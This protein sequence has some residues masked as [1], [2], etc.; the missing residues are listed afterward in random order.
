M[1]HLYKVEIFG[2]NYQYKDMALLSELSIQMDYLTL[3]NTTITVVNLLAD[4]GDFVHITD[5]YGAIIHQGIVLDV[6]RE[7]NRAKLKVA[8]LHTS[9]R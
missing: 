2:R 8:P 7:S 3:E 9:R 6:A 4:K 5:F 1:R